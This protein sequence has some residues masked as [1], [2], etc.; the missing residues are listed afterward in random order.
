MFEVKEETQFPSSIDMYCGGIHSMALD[1]TVHWAKKVFDQV[2]AMMN[3]SVCDC[4][5][6]W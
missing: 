2:T 5:M 3:D 1:N 4:T 6:D